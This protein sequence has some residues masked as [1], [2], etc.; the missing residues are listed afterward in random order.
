MKFNESVKYLYSLGNEVGAMKLGLENPRA[1][2]RALGNP[3]D[4]FNKA[5]VAGTNGKGSVCAFL[6]AICRAAGIKTGLYTSPH[7][8]SLT[9]RVKINGLDIS[10]PDFARHAW[11]VRNAAEN[12][13]KS[14]AA[15]PTFFEQMTAIALSGFAEAEIELAILETGMG[16]RL[17]AT[18]AAEAYIAVIT[19]IALDHQQYLG[20][21]LREIAAEKAAIIRA[22][23]P[24]LSSP[25][26]PEAMEVIASRAAECGVELKITTPHAKITG[27]AEDGA[28]LVTIST[29][30]DIYRDVRLGLLGRHQWVNAALAVETA[31]TL[32]EDG[33]SI[34]R[35]DIIFGLHAARHKGRLEYVNGIL[36]DG[37]H[38]AAGAAALATYLNGSVR[39]PITMIFGAMNDKDISGMAAAL[40]PKAERLI[41][42]KID[43]TRSAAPTGLRNMA[44]NYLQP[45]KISVAE[46]S[47]QALAIAKDSL[48][49]G[50]LILVT[51]SLYLVGEVRKLL[52]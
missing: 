26:P 41:L 13:A 20:G 6:D 33:F 7:L 15:L 40:F 35:E 38:N 18:T 4:N 28:E 29:P 11:S 3:Q 51:G 46:T 12:M 9:E 2:F 34:S 5:Q 47:A 42:T 37:A 48:P 10:E 45:E 1:L 50:G 16:G 32:R 49:P 31:E 19:P 22:G 24:A 27:F 25:Q 30:N 14:G 39:R 43:N 21:T 23:I 17:D 44:L 52:S 8:V 36:F